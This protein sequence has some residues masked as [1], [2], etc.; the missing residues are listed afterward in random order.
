M[1]RHKAG[2]V[3]TLICFYNFAEFPHVIDVL[4]PFMC[5]Y[6]PTWWGQGPDNADPTP[7]GSHVTMVT[8]DHL[9]SLLR[10]ILKVW[11]RVQMSL[12]QRLIPFGP[13][14][15]TTRRCHC[16]QIAWILLNSYC[17]AYSL[18]HFDSI[19]GVIRTMGQGIVNYCVAVFYRPNLW[20]S[21]L[22]LIKQ[23]AEYLLFLS[24]SSSTSTSA[25]RRRSG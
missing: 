20:I 25:T 2:T 5:T 21:C 24:R 14:H 1:V 13:E 8:S 19:S 12:L 3:E 4:L 18:C 11:Q 22:S 6:L 17:A 10:L 15:Q 7:S 9:N 16:N 23:N